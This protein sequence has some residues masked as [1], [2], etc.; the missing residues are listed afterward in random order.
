MDK[1]LVIG[2][3]GRELAIGWSI[4]QDKDVEVVWYAPGNKGTHMEEK[5]NNVSAGLSKEDFVGLEAVVDLQKIDMIVVGPEQPLVDGIVDFFHER[6]FKNI[7]GPIRAA[8]VIES[9]KFYSYRLME[10]L[11]IP[12]AESILCETTKQAEDAIKKMATDEGIVIKA[13]GLTGGKGVYVCDSRDE[14]LAIL[15]EHA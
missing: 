7:F 10:E 14:A 2:S 8:S 12:Q 6:D 11:N 9:D 13:R 1:V 4:A 5:G 3:G 15:K